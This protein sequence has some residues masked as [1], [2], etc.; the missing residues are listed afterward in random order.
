M[1]RSQD[2][3]LDR[4]KR[5]ADSLDLEAVVDYTVASNIGTVS[6]QEKDEFT[7]LLS[8]KFNFQ[9]GYAIFDAVDGWHEDQKDHWYVLTAKAPSG[10]GFAEHPEV[11][12]DVVKS[13]LKD[14]MAEA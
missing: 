3:F 6:F 9:N 8:F 5:I 7:F 1:R 13:E 14:R 4:M 2:K 11:F 10:E 12:I